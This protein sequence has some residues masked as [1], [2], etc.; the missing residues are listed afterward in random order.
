MRIAV[1]SRNFSSAGGGAERYSIA[2]VEHLAADHEVHVFAQKIEHADPR[3]HYHRIALPAK[4]PRWINQLWFAFATWKNTRA[5]FDIVHSHENSWHGNVQTV[6]V[7]PVRYTLFKGQTSWAKAIEWIKVLTSLRLIVYLVLESARYAVKDNRNRRGNGKRIVLASETLR[8][9][10]ERVYPFAAKAMEV[11]PPGIDNSPGRCTF[12]QQVQVRQTLGLPIVGLGI[13]FVANDFQRKGLVALLAALR[14]LPD[15][16]WLSVVGRDAQM[17]TVRLQ[18]AA[19]GLAERVFFLGAQRDM[20]LAYQAADCLAHPTREDTYA[21]V[22]L[23][24]MSH[25]LP[26]VVSAARYCGI[27]AELENGVNALILDDPL[28]A[29][30]LANAL[31]KILFTDRVLAVAMGSAAQA[32]AADRTWARAAQRYARIYAELAPPR[33]QRWLVLSHAF[34]MD[35][36]AASQTI[37]DKLPHLTRAGIE[38]VVLSGVSGN[39]DVFYEHYPLWPA[40]PAGIRFELRHVLRKRFGKRG[41]G[42]VYRLVMLSCTIPL[43]PFMALEKLFRPVESSWSWWISAYYKGLVLMRR[44]HFDLIYSTGGAFSAHLAGAALKRVSGLPWLAEVH[45]PFVVPGTVPHSAQQKMQ[46]KV[47]ALICRDADIAIWFTDAALASARQRNPGLGARGRVMLPGVDA[48]N[49]ELKPYLPSEKFVIGHFGSLSATRNLKYVIEAIDQ[50]M[51]EDS[52]IRDIVELHVYG[53]PLDAV[54][55]V[56]VANSRFLYVK[57]F[58]RLENDPVSGRTGR[59]QILQRMASA[60]VLLLLHGIEPIC[61]EYIPSKLY[62]YLWMGRPILA[63][64]H[65]NPQL[66][67]ILLA[68]RHRVVATWQVPPE[69]AN[70]ALLKMHGDAY[71]NNDQDRPS[72]EIIADLRGEILS[73]FQRWRNHDLASGPLSS[74]YTT[75]ASVAQMLGFWAESRGHQSDER[76][77]RPSSY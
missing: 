38:P 21:M 56:A 47:E 46:A 77:A 61:A 6:H 72:A 16:V 26:V 22:V 71:D 34:N 73:L 53:G 32:F 28:D 17:E 12:A 15:Q 37:T 44:Q 52:N 64:V 5:G 2:L 59:E 43:L 20:R 68:Q 25:G 39:R 33:R 8:R 24:A 63:L 57:H 45:D 7:L 11:I 30:A 49:T 60:D 76:T 75:R 65:D 51:D 14:E 19:M 58:G 35:G 42:L 50:W 41:N 1:L 67:D 62:E 36:R 40:G 3:V 27:S 69:P 54:S 66:C 13:L 10:M 74:I 4:T 55:A 29:Q 48:T 23:E 18:V 9:T 31:K 70:S